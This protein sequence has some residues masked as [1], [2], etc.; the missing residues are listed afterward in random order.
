M[1]LGKQQVM[2]H[3]PG[4]C[5]PRERSR[6]SSML[7]ASAWPSPDAC[8]HDRVYQQIQDFSFSS[9]PVT[10]YF[11]QRNLK[12]LTHK[13]VKWFHYEISKRTGIIWYDF[14]KFHSHLV[15]SHFSKIT[16]CDRLERKRIQSFST[17]SLGSTS[18]N[19]TKGTAPLHPLSM[20]GYYHTL[21]RAIK[22]W[23]SRNYISWKI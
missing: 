10:L 5:Q 20:C 6:R 8:S 12:N 1:H 13:L 11:P 23:H 14:V 4:P 17:D 18:L 21:Q 16:G 7:L 15:L 2:D 22:E 19:C 9:L 3:E